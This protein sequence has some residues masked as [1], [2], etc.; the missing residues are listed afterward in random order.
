MQELL[1]KKLG[2]IRNSKYDILSLKIIYHRPQK[3]KTFPGAS[4]TIGKGLVWG[5]PI[6]VRRKVHKDIFKM[7]LR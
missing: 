7:F 1:K 6:S 3:M 2:D 4:G 5:R